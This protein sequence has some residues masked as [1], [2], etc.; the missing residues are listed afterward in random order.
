MSGHSEGDLVR[1]PT[2]LLRK[3][4]YVAELD[5]PWTELPTMYQGLELQTDADIA[6]LQQHCRYVYVIPERSGQ[7]ESVTLAKQTSE[8]AYTHPGR[9][10]GS[11]NFAQ[12]LGQGRH[13][14]KR[15]FA[16]DVQAAA[17]ARREARTYLARALTSIRNRRAID[18]ETAEEVI[19][20]VVSA[21][22]SNANAMV[23]LTK[24]TEEDEPV[25]VHS[26]NVC[27][28]SIYLATHLALG[29]QLVR[30]IALGALLHDIGKAASRET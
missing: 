12:G 4:L 17:S 8:T 28:L 10:H 2:Q 30:N 29:H 11:G 19:D 6:L 25:V 1:V 14:D 9:K 16:V 24:L 5:R 27:I 22:E 3:G 21:V 20:T 15:E 7:H 26:L 13:P 23:W 18:I